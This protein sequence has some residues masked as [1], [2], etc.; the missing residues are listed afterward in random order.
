MRTWPG[1]P[2]DSLALVRQSSRPGLRPTVSGRST[3]TAITGKPPGPGGVDLAQDV[4]RR[5]IEGLK[6]LGCRS[7][8]ARTGSWPV[9][10]LDDQT[11]R[12][13]RHGY[14]LSEVAPVAL[15]DCGEGWGW[16]KDDH[17][18]LLSGVVV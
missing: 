11:A 4:L 12:S 3:V 2:P 8:S 18:A 10:L 6:Q 17:Q 16:G 5:T 9:S 7:A 14:G 1:T 13:R 15:V